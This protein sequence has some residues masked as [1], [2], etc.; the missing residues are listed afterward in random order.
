[1]RYHII[2]HVQTIQTQVFKQI[3]TRQL[4]RRHE[5]R[6]RAIRLNAPEQA[7]YTLFPNHAYQ[8]IERM[9]VVPPLG[10]R[11]REIRLHP[12]VQHVGGVA[13]DAAA[14]AGERGHPD[15]TAEGEG[16]VGVRGC[17]GRCEACLE[18]FV[19]AEADGAVG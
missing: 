3:V 19:D 10:R 9:F 15:Q 13:N 18:V 12:H 5:Q 1:M 16:R 14:E 7:R 8:P 6:P 17:G 4:T 2:T 11:L